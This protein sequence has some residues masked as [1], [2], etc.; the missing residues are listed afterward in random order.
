MSRSRRSRNSRKRNSSFFDTILQIDGKK[1]ICILLILFLIFLLS[2][3][4]SKLLIASNSKKALSYDSQKV[5]SISDE[6][7]SSQNEVSMDEDYTDSNLLENRSDSSN[8]SSDSS[9][10]SD[11]SRSFTL[12]AIGDVMCHNTQYWDAY[13][14]STGEYDFSYVFKDIV[15]Y[16]MSPD[17]TVGSLETSF[18]GADRGYSNYPTFNSPDNLAYSLRQIG[19]DVLSTAGNHCL[20]MGYSGL[21][22][23]ID[24]LDGYGISHLG[25]YKTQDEQKQILYNY[26]KGTKIAFVNYTYG[27][28]GIPIPDGK[29]FCVNLINK[30]LIKTQLDTAKSEGADIIVACMHWGT[31]YRTTANSEQEE[32]AD[33][34]FQNGVDVILGNHPHTLEPMEKRTVTLADGS[35]K[36]CFVIYALGNFICDQNYENTRNSIILN[37]R[38]THSSDNKISI[39]RVTYTPIHIYKNPNLSIQRFKVLD[40]EKAIDSYEDGSDTSIGKAKYDDLKV[41]L[42]KIKSIVGDE[43]LE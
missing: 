37:L 16:T 36:D 35:T 28:N 38:I 23:T 26:V 22:R 11:S 29:E 2:F 17:I 14:K 32:L 24:V 8:T 21:C 39:D 13:V 31:E 3:T 33:F 25:T 41:Q 18:A 7:K 43:I 4:C 34:L 5:A 10:T 42:E 30:D 19:V 27:T 6:E 1:V 40:I 15:K 9:S 20:D 12:C